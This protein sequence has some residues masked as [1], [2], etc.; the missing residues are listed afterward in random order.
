MRE[1]KGERKKCKIKGEKTANSDSSA[2][3]KKKETLWP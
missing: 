3:Q 2:Q 1:G